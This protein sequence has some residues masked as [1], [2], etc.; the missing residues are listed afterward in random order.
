[1]RAPTTLL[2]A[3]LV[4][5]AFLALLVA[6]EL[7][8][9]APREDGSPRYPFLLE[10]TTDRRAYLER[11]R[12][13]P[14]GA[15]PYLEEFSEYPQ[16]ST[17]M[18][19]LPYLL[20]DAGDEPAAT[21]AVRA[22]ARQVFV[23]A[24]LTRARAEEVL[25]ELRR[26]AGHFDPALR[27]RAGQ[28]PVSDLLDLLEREAGLARPAAEEQVFAVWEAENRRLE[29]LRSTFRTYGNLHHAFMALWFL[30]LIA[31][32]VAILSQ[33]RLPPAYALLMLLPGGL[34]FGFNRHDLPVMVLVLLALWL[35]FAGRYRFAALALGLGIMTKWYPLVLVPLLLSHGFWTERRRA[36]ARG[37][38][39]PLVGLLVRQVLLPGL[40]V[41]AV[42][43]SVLAITYLWHGG[44]LPAVTALFEWHRAVREPNHASL[45]ALMTSADAWGWLPLEARAVWMDRFSLLQLVPPFLIALLPLRSRAALI[46]AALLATLGM[47]LFSKFFSPQ[48]VLWIV[49]L[50]I[51]RAPRRRIYLLLIVAL[52]VVIYLQ[53]PVFFFSG[54]EAMRR[55]EAEAMGA[56]FWYATNTRV[57]LLFAFYLA[58]LWGLSR[59]LLARDPD[60]TGAEVHSPM[61]GTS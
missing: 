9:A 24:G 56:A 8:G 31:L 43:A 52:Q 4:L 30:G 41:G 13:L 51:L 5:G 7:W 48:W 20:M 44:G 60:G 2:V 40:V 3:A 50:A 12:W 32:L 21:R 34:Y 1:M 11:G 17:W 55:G 42:I 19:G 23:E 47:V 28:H 61:R 10:D 54:M 46:E 29:E 16:L 14:A 25:R 22:R 26:R 15:T 38:E 37:E 49:A 59:A 35:Q 33:L 53:L 45:L 39:A 36:A 27:G 18:M 58:A 6:T 57:A